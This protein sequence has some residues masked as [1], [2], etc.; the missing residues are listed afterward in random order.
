M[1]KFNTILW[2]KRTL[3]LIILIELFIIVGVLFT[4]TGIDTKP[5][6]DQIKNL[7]TQI[8][9]LDDTNLQLQ[10]SIDNMYEQAEGYE[11]T[12][13]ELTKDLAKVKSNTNEKINSVNGYNVDELQKF[14][15]D[16]Y[17]TL[18]NN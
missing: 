17:D 10:V 6:E 5:Y 16:R 13:K 18:P 11:L 14:F 2:D 7:Q 4:D 9:L 8:E 3:L 1:K 15:T 12:I